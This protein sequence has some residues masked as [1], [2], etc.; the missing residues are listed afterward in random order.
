MD[1]QDHTDFRYELTGAPIEQAKQVFFWAHG[2]GQNRAAFRALCESI[3]NAA[4]VLLDFPGFG[5]SPLP[6]LHWGTADYADASA[7]LIKKLMPGKKI[8]WAGHSFGCRVGIQL[9]ARHPELLDGMILIAGAGLPRQRSLIERVKLKWRIVSFKFARRIA[10]IFPA[11]EK[12]RGQ[13]GSADYR[14]AGPL[15]PLFVR[16]VNE[17]LTDIA[18][19]VQ[20]P[21]L[22]IY[23]ADDTE[24]PP[25]IGQRLNKLIPNS[26]LVIMPGH[27]HYSVLG[28]GRH[29]VAKYLLQFTGKL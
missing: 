12:Y 15:R 21:T 9:G 24:T 26:E 8:I 14:N 19:D 6:P 1:Y 27:D 17:N 29:L 3:P 23:G 4:H 11:L 2:W 7:T 5:E 18:R 28:A 20:C 25:E 16:V 22:L 10:N 13:M